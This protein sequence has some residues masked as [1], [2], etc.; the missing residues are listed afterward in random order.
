MEN[1]NKNVTKDECIFEHKRAFRAL[2]D[3]ALITYDDD[4]FLLIRW[5]FNDDREY[6]F[7]HYA[8]DGNQLIWW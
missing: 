8:K 7:Y 6:Q 5:S 4:G 2:R 1:Y 3:P